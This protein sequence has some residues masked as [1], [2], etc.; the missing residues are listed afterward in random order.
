[1][2]VLFCVV[3]VAAGVGAGVLVSREVPVEPAEE[4]PLE[5]ELARFV[6]LSPGEK[7][8]FEASSEERSRTLF[9]GVTAWEKVEGH[10]H[11][12]LEVGTAR[13]LLTIEWLRP[14]TSAEGQPQLL[15][16]Q[17]RIGVRTYAVRP[18][19]PLLQA[20]LEVGTSWSWSGTAGEVPSESTFRIVG[21]E[22]RGSKDLLTVEQVTTLHGE[23]TPLVSRVVQTYAAGEGL[24]LEESRVPAHDP[25][26]REQVDVR[27][28]RKR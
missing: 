26:R 19:Q 9:R 3:L 11:A 7:V 28:E 12:R 23:G 6:P 22:R 15:C 4:Q 21:R 10:P 18:P 5:E 8:E 1:M 20:P 24:I 16:S 27:S 2:A 17:R 25:P 13:R 14:G